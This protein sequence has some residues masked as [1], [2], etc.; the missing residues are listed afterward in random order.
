MGKKEKAP[1]VSREPKNLKQLFII[2][3][4]LEGVSV[5]IVEIAGARA[6]APFYGTS[7]KVWTAQI[8]ATLLFLALGYWVGGVLSKKPGKFS[9]PAVFLG[10]GLW[11]ILFPLLRVPVLQGTASML[12]IAGGSFL[13]ATILYG[14]PLLALGAVSPLLIE[15]LG[16]LGTGAGSAAGTLFFTNTIGGLAGGWLTALW[17]IPHFPLRLV[18][19]G[20][21]IVLILIGAFWGAVLKSIKSLLSVTL[22]GAALV[23]TLIIPAPATSFKLYGSQASIIFA[24]GTALGLIQVM[25]MPALGTRSLLLDG[26]IQGGEMQGLSA[27]PFT[28]YQNYLGHRYHPSAGSALVLG[29]GAGV[30]AKQLVRRGLSVT[31]VELEKDIGEVARE[32]FSLPESVRLIYED[33]RTYLNRTGETYDVVFL[34]VYAGESIPWY[35]TTREAMAL[36]RNVLNPGGRL[37]INSMT[38]ASGTSP[39]LDRLES[40]LVDAFDDALVFTG[41]QA[42]GPKGREVTNAILVA[43]SD[44]VPSTEP[45]PGKVLPW[46]LPQLEAVARSVRT[47]KASV[48]VPTDDWNDLDY[49]GADLKLSWREIIVNE[50]GAAVLG[51]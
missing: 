21:G 19:S 33:A 26:A 17:L 34:D 2:T 15:R 46:I 48:E 22:P 8:T 44:L 16:R 29:L 41:S 9:L 5:L 13:S 6:L 11:L 47:A 18:L 40:V 35:L 38:W 32:F 3:A 49:A 4:F 39:D 23:L 28:E 12:G 31:A 10:A 42:A 43:G 14:P 1:L 7:L 25:D 51:D 50:L 20:T 37:V 30:L 36:I 27:Y 24:K 45:Y